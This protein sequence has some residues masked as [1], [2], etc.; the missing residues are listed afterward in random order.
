MR[1]DLLGDLAREAVG[2]PLGDAGHY[3][4]LQKAHRRRGEVDREQGEQ[5]RPDPPEVYPARSLHLGHH[6]RVE[7]GRGLPEDLRS[8]HAEHRGGDGA[9]DGDE[10][11]HP[12]ASEIG[13]EPARGATEVLC[14]VH[15]MGKARAS[16]L[17]VVLL[18]HYSSPPSGPAGTKRTTS[19]SS[20]SS[21]EESWLMAIS[22]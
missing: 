11:G 2:D 14:L 16:A 7:L 8:H 3:P 9:Y 15:R 4:T 21:A 17:P 20:P 12:M 18:G 10:H 22:R 6:A 5:D 13:E 1:A 19:A